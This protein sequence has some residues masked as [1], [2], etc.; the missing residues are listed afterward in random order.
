VPAV[1]IARSVPRVIEAYLGAK[2]HCAAEALRHIE[3]VLGVLRLDARALAL[4]VVQQV[5]SK[6]E[7]T[8]PH[9]AEYVVEYVELRAAGINIPADEQRDGSNPSE[10]NKLHIPSR[11][12]L[13]QRSRAF[14]Y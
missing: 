5:R 9:R 10:L 7:T 13:Q 14:S 4:F 12:E 1:V 3:G 2:H 6:S 8:T 11:S